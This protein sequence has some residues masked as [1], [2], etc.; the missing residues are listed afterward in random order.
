MSSIGVGT[1]DLQ[2]AFFGQ[3]NGISERMLSKKD[4][5]KSSQKKDIISV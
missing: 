5:V 1:P 3:G 2:K 4:Q